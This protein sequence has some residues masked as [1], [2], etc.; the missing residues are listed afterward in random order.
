MC[1]HLGICLYW[2]HFYCCDKIPGQRA[3]QGERV[4]VS[5]QLQ[6]AVIL[7]ETSQQQDLKT[8][9]TLHTQK[10]KE[11]NAYIPRISLRRPPA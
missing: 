7:S 5:S 8:A 10:Q 4:Y 6:A 1:T 11:M 2:S 3:T 9:V